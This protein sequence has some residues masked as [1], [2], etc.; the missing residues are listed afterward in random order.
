MASYLLSEATDGWALL[1][2][3][4][5][6]GTAPAWPNAIPPFVTFVTLLRWVGF[7]ERNERK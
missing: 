5:G 1:D 4:G 7:R 6:Y 3:Q 2:D